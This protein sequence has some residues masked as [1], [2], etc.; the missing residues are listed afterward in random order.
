MMDRILQYFSHWIFS[1]SVLA[2]AVILGI[3]VYWIVIQMVS[4]ITRRRSQLLHE[5]ILSHCRGPFR[6]IF[7]AI[8]LLLCL[9]VLEF[10][11][12]AVDT[13]GDFI[14]VLLIGSVAWLFIRLIYVIEDLVLMK[15]NIQQKDNLRAR[16]IHTQFG[17]VKRILIVIIGTFAIA[18][19]LMSFEKFSRIGT[20]ILASAGVLGLVVG[21]A[22]QRTIGNLLAGI[23]IAVT[24]P[25]RLDDVVVVENEWGKVE[26]ISL[27]YVVIKLWDLRRLI[28]PI[29][30]FIEKP[31]QNWTRVSAEILGTVLFYVDYSVPVQAVRG[32][33]FRILKDSDLWD[34]KTWNLEVT[35]TTEHTVELRALVGSWN[36]DTL[37]RLRC[38]VREKL[39]EF[40]QKTYP[41]A[42]P[43]VRALLEEAGEEK[44]ISPPLRTTGITEK[45]E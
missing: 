18:A 28:L 1:V 29:S 9:S 11:K 12:R 30:Y 27:T 7:P 2:A 24:Q 15:Y 13:I 32:E 19:A 36:S 23:Q 5:S 35:N 21:L 20:G 6:I 14:S 41:H 39:I 37:W 22:A 8:F 31:F 17:I 33:L 42:L 38:E 40:I 3:I 16:R 43:K 34:G 45:R 4:T 10:S 26:E 25:I 44:A